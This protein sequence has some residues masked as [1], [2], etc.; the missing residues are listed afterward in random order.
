M[1]LHMKPERAMELLELALSE[2]ES[3]ED[4]ALSFSEGLSRCLSSP[5]HGAFFSTRQDDAYELPW[6]DTRNLPIDVVSATRSLVRETPH[7]ADHFYFR[8]PH[9]AAL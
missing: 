4:W 1:G 8:P 5:I 6:G 2:G 3:F 9:V 7:L